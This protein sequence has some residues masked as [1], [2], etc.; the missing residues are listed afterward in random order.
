MQGPKSDRWAEDGFRWEIMRKR[1]KRP[2][3]TVIMNNLQMDMILKDVR[4]FLS[5]QG[6][7]WYKDKGLPL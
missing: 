1:T 5:R 2:L 6:V 4:T 3:R 7:R